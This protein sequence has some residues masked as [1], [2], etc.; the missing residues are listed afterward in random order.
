MDCKT[1][2]V[3]FFSIHQA[4]PHLFVL[5]VLLLQ[6]IV[7]L[8]T[9]LGW[10]Q[11][12]PSTFPS[13]LAFIWIDDNEEVSKNRLK[14]H[15]RARP[16]CTC[17]HKLHEI[18]N[19]SRMKSNEHREN[20]TNKLVGGWYCSFRIDCLAPFKLKSLNALHYLTVF[21][22]IIE[23]YCRWIYDELNVNATNWKC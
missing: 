14:N 20:T 18:K 23:S 17:W 15:W 8:W 9:F 22:R 10:H 12:F 19:K 1:V 6:Y 3:R 13:V 2:K 21:S 11:Q 16:C 4:Y 7:W 5:V